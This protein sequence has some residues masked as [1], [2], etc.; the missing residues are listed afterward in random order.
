MTVIEIP[1]YPYDTVV[2]FLEA[3]MREGGLTGWLLVAWERNDMRAYRHVD[4]TDPE[5]DIW[6]KAQELAVATFGYWCA[7]ERLPCR[8]CWD[9]QR[10]DKC[11]TG[12][13]AAQL[14]RTDG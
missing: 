13:C 10:G 4:W 2:G 14:G 8:E 11:A 1:G 5:S 7:G 3:A 12:D 9:A 6:R